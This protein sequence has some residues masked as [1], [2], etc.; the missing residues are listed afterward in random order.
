MSALN[1]TGLTP[2]MGAE[3][4]GLDLAKPLAGPD[5]A[6]LRKALAEH[7]LL[8]IRGQGHVTPE[9][10]IAFSRGFGPLEEHV[11]SNFCLEGHPEI[12]VVSNIME[13]GRHIGA[14]GGAKVFHSDLMYLPEPSLGSVF[15]CLE[16]PDEGGQTAFASLF[17][18]YD[19]LPETRKKWLAGRR[20]VYDYVWDYARRH[21][22][23]PALTEA[24]KA[25]VPPVT[26]PAVRL[27]PVT[28]RPSLFFS[29]VWARRFEDMGEEES[30]PIFEELTECATDQ[31]FIYTHTWTPGDVLIWDNRS[32]MHRACPFD[33]QNARRLM[34]R[35]TVK[36]DRPVGVQEAA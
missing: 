7:T 27:H 6:A 25:K 11:L 14:Y 23:R 18:A 31:R 34:H 13:N 24:Q 2:F 30:R 16:C 21:R 1:L 35:T 36:G 5:A 28:G 22:D 9:Q 32:S 29:P 10:H 19:A 17:A 20:I 26:H 12:F 8:L 15:R 3:L 4:H 33:E